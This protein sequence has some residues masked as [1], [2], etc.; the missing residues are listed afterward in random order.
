MLLGMCDVGSVRIIMCMHVYVRIHIYIHECTSTHISY[1]YLHVCT[2][3]YVPCFQRPLLCSACACDC[4]RVLPYVAVCCSM[5]QCGMLQ[6]T[7]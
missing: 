6:F 1:I 5:L 2:Y 7:T 3:T 4:D